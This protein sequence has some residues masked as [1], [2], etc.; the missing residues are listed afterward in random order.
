MHAR[1]PKI[2]RARV[3]DKAEIARRALSALRLRKRSSPVHLHVEGESVPVAVPREA[4]DL[5]LE[6]LRLTADGK[7]AAV[8]P[9][10]S[11]VTTQQAAELLN[12]SRPYLVGLLDE[13]R[14]PFRLVGSHRR[15]RMDDLL[16]FKQADDA[17]RTAILDELTSEAQRQGLGY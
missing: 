13:G 6:I 5:F 15:V 3:A 12:V 4:F 8:L 10:H 16:A 17:R 1:A 7:T 14:I 9:L 11:E 2:A